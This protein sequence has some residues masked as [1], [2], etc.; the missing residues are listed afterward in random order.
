MQVV[1]PRGYVHDEVAEALTLTATAADDLIRFATDLAD[2]L[3]ATFAALAAGEI[4]YTKARTLWHGTALAGE[5]VTAQVEAL[6]LLKAPEQTTGE[7]RAK[8][9][10]L[11]KRLDPGALARRRTRAEG[12]RDVQLFETDDGTAHL[13]GADLPA[14]RRAPPSTGSTRSLP[15]SRPTETGVTSD[16]CVPT[17]SSACSPAP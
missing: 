11:V 10:R 17:C 1:S 6:V 15:G 5:L 3:P 4:D 2:R 7:L 12:Q 8:V 14:E 16:T 9:R 13:S